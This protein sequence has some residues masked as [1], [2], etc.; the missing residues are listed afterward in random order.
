MSPSLQLLIVLVIILVVAKASGLLAVRI[1]QPAVLGELAAGVI[2]GPSIIDI[3][4]FDFLNDGQF[5][6]ARQTQDRPGIQE[7]RDRS[8]HCFRHRDRRGPEPTAETIP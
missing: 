1:G 6:R 2:L 7:R 4:G 3:F 8:R 5:I